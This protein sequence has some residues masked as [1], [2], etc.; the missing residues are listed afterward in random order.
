MEKFGK[1]N[2]NQGKKLRD[3]KQTV[4]LPNKYTAVDIFLLRACYY[5]INL[6]TESLLSPCFI[7]IFFFTAS[8]RSLLAVAE[9]MLLK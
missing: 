2:V 6:Y 1:L 7:S 8:A 9:D 4:T 5:F 3:R